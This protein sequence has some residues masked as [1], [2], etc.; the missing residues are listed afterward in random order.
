MKTRSWPVLSHI[1]REMT[2]LGMQRGDLVYGD[3]GLLYERT[4]ETVDDRTR[5]KQLGLDAK[6]DMEDSEEVAGAMKEIEASD[7]AWANWSLGVV[8]DADGDHSLEMNKAASSK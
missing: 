1:G 3:D 4:A 7:D 5:K 6:A 2:A 8:I